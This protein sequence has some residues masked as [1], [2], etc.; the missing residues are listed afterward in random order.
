MKLAI[1]A[2]AVLAAWSGF[3]WAAP[4]SATVDDLAFMAGTWVQ[5]DASGLVRETWLGPEGGMLV[6]ANLTAGA[7]GRTSFEFA[8]VAPTPEGPTFFAS[9]GGA[10]PTAFPLKSFTGGRAVFEQLGHDFPQRVI[11]WRCEADLCAR[12]EGSIGGKAQSM[13]WRFVRAEAR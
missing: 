12:I 6:G 8:R 11:Y 2:A 3:A 10:A 4:P 1:V 5:R 7:N 9:P 13:D